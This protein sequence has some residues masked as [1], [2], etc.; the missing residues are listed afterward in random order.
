MH[1]LQ[2][3]FSEVMGLSPLASQILTQ[4]LQMGEIG[5]DTSHINHQPAVLSDPSAGLLFYIVNYY[6][7]F[8]VSLCSI[9][10]G[11]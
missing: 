1:H 11:H 5:V 7:A 9:Y 2:L 8:T 4:Q 6:Y 3:N 10:F